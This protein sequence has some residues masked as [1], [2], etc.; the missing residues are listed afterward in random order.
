MTTISKT[1]VAWLLL[2]AAACGQDLTV[3]AR[4]YYRVPKV[5]LTTVGDIVL[6][7]SL[8]PLSVAVREAK[9][10]GVVRIDTEASKVEMTVSGE[11]RQPIQPLKITENIW[12]IEKPGKW[13]VD[14]TAID[15]EKGIYGRKLVLVEVGGTPPG[16]G[17]G[18]GPDPNPDPAPDD[19]P[20]EYGVGKVAFAAAPGEAS[21]LRA[22]AKIYKQAGDFL[23]GVPSLK[24][25]DSSNSAQSRDPN[26]SVLAWLVQQQG[27]VQCTDQV[28]CDQWAA[29]RQKVSVALIESQKRRQ[30]TRQDWYN[31]FNEISRALSMKAGQ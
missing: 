10:V 15:F 6:A 13:W 11:D 5:E 23:F 9:S 4:T 25:I 30:F 29:W 26:R 21:S 18:P 20:N 2:L 1:A 7:D 14:V 19:I 8:E 31:A 3:K 28:I 16:P 17:P 27:L 12:L 22:Y 24:F